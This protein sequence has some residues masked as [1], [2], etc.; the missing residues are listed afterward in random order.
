[1]KVEAFIDQILTM[2]NSFLTDLQSAKITTR[3]LVTAEFIEAGKSA[4]LPAEHVRLFHFP[5]MLMD[6][7]FAALELRVEIAHKGRTNFNVIDSKAIESLSDA[8]AKELIEQARKCVQNKFNDIKLQTKKN[9]DLAARFNTPSLHVFTS[10]CFTGIDP[11]LV[12]ALEGHGAAGKEFYSIIK[13]NAIKYGFPVFDHSYAGDD[14]HPKENKYFLTVS[15]KNR[16][17]VEIFLN[18]VSRERTL[19]A[20]PAGTNALA[21]ARASRALDPAPSPAGGAGISSCE[22]AS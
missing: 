21:I 4:K 9:A 19:V 2:L 3:P 14:G 5:S 13:S 17:D 7:I 18:K 10:L 11:G 20:A 8:K 12:L 6:E 1:M 22:H 15:D 16:D